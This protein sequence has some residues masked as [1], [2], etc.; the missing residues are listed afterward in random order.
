MDNDSN[1]QLR[2]LLF[3]D[4]QGPI[5]LIQSEPQLLALGSPGALLTGGRSLKHNEDMGW[6]MLETHQLPSLL[7]LTVQKI[8]QLKGGILTLPEDIGL[9]GG[10]ILHWWRLLWRRDRGSMFK[11]TN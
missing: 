10:S 2:R 1:A 4:R 7:P 5:R 8:L 6:S 11:R 3:N 9:A